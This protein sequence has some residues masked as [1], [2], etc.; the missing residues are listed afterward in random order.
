[1]G[2]YGGWVERKLISTSGEEVN[3][4]MAKR[5][6]ANAAN[7]A[8]NAAAQQNTATEFASE[9]N[10]AQVRRQNQQ[11]ANRANQTNNPTT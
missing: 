3:S 11:S 4:T 10:V 1:M 8:A 9:T 2:A 6:R 5:N 7:P